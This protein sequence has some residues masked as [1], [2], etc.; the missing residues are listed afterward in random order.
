M[1]FLANL[2]FTGLDFIYGLLLLLVDHILSIIGFPDGSDDKEFACNAG[3]TGF[4]L[5][6]GISPRDG[7]GNPLQY[8]CLEHSID[9]GAWQTTV[10][11]SKSCTKLNN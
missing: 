4:I 9:R 10:H 2:M 7:S 3:D 1:N 8:F 5:G 6:S 11:G